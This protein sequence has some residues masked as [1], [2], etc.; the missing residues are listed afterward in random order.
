MTSVNKKKHF[1]HLADIAIGQ[2]C[3]VA[4]I[5]S[6]R[7]GDGA[8]LAVAQLTFGSLEDIPPA[9]WT[10]RQ[11]VDIFGDNRLGLNDDIFL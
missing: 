11:I 2:L 4:H 9:L 5:G 1:K 10:E 6:G 7:L 3:L 8:D